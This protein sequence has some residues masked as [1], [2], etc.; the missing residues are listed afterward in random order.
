MVVSISSIEEKFVIQLRHKINYVVE[1]KFG[2]TRPETKE[3]PIV[4]VQLFFS[5]TGNYFSGRCSANRS[6]FLWR[7]CLRFTDFTLK[8]YQAVLI[9]NFTY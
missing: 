7:Y 6:F 1:K 5:I 4:L 3:Q 2:R 8:K 9:K